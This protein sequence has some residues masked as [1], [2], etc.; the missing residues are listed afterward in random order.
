MD[1]FIKN[2]LIFIFPILILGIGIEVLMR[3]IPNVYSYKKA[4]LDKNS[5]KLKVLYL[6]QSHTFFGINPSYSKYKSFNAAYV[7]QSIDLDWAILRKYQSQWDS[8]RYI[9]IPVDYFSLFSKLENGVEASRMKNY[10][11]YYDIDP[12][13]YSNILN[14]FEIFS[15]TPITLKEKIQDYYIRK[16]PP[17]IKC[18]ELGY[19]ST[20]KNGK[21][22]LIVTGKKDA[23]LHTRADKGNFNEI[24]KDLKSILEFAEAKKIKVL[25]FTSP[26]YYSYVQN[27]DT[28]QLNITYRTIAELDKSHGNVT[29]IDLLTDSSFNSNDFY[30]ADHLN[31]IGA[32]KLTMKL[33]SIISFLDKP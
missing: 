8:L 14:K 21:R 6:G 33:D 7:S 22:D 9:V 19:Y 10:R 1:K 31:D 4:Y 3:N 26:A 5:R 13:P 15:N 17:S 2:T 12:N 16:I 32:Q 24:F 23:E 18:S 25:I 20:L 28:N 29:Y 30:D 27:L 11:I